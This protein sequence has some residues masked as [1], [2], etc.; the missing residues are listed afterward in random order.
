MQI[1]GILKRFWRDEDGVETVEWALIAAVLAVAVLA[2]YKVIG[3]SLQT[4][5]NNV[6]D[7]LNTG[8]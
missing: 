2:G 5:L 7:H 4:G 6:A 8:T 1:I 3:P